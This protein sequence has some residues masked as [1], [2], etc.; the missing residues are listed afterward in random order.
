MFWLLKLFSSPLTVQH[1][2]AIQ[3][4]NINLH[5]ELHFSLHNKPTDRS[6]HVFNV[7]LDIVLTGEQFQR[8][9]NNIPLLH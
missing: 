8:L 4:I 9:P 2:C 1:S 7:N 5:G 6:N 3:F